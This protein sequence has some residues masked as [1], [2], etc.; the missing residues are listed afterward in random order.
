[1]PFAPAFRKSDRHARGRM[2]AGA[3]GSPRIQV[4]DEFA[5]WCLSRIPAGAD[6]EA[7]ANPCSAEELL[8]HIPPFALIRRA[9]AHDHRVDGKARRARRVQRLGRAGE[10]EFSVLGVAQ[11][12]DRATSGFRGEQ[13]TGIAQLN[14][15]HQRSDL[16]RQ[17]LG[18]LGLCL[19]LNF[20]PGGQRITRLL[21]SRLRRLRASRILRLRLTEGFSW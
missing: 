13:G 5:G 14:T 4:D 20:D 19:N 1:M 17:N 8:P 6:G 10:N 2:R 9:F 11:G 7:A 12:H 3:E 18:G 21:A 16:G 15:A